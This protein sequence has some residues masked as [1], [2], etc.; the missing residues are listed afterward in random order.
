M[1]RER[2]KPVYS[3]REI[4]REGLEDDNMKALPFFREMRSRTGLERMWAS[5]EI[6]RGVRQLRESGGLDQFEHKALRSLSSLSDRMNP[7][8]FEYDE[9]FL[10]EVVV[11]VVRHA[12]GGEEFL[13]GLHRGRSMEEF[14]AL[15]D[16][17]PVEGAPRYHPIEGRC[18]YGECTM[19]EREGHTTAE[20]HW[21]SREISDA[22]RKAAANMKDP[23]LNDI[24]RRALGEVS[25]LLELSPN[26]VPDAVVAVLRH[27]PGG[28]EYLRQ[29]QA[30]RSMEDYRNRF[31]KK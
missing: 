25:Q 12:P 3:V 1:L 2:D 24:E 23:G 29:L 8:T 14:M 31:L 16:R 9:Y 15:P 19:A 5:Y 17:K 7:E 4:I 30:G 28:K 6:F 26:S 22:S 13:K 18:P 21:A 11:A 20:W 10:P 27:V